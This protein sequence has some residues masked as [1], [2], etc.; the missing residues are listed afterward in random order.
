MNLVHV[1][2]ARSINS[3]VESLVKRVQVAVGVVRRAIATD[4][5]LVGPHCYEYFVCKRN[6]NQHQG[7]KWEFPGGKVDVGESIVDA[8]NRELKEEIGISTLKTT[9]LTL[10]QF[11][12]PD[13]KVELHVLVVDQF[14]GDAHG[15]EGQESKWATFDELLSF[16]FPDANQE[17]LTKLQSHI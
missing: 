7:G 9:P 6:A 13:K 5:S 11:D 3:V 2:Q 16:D 1:A 17:I 8:L 14:T 4:A 10:I 15:A 12:Y